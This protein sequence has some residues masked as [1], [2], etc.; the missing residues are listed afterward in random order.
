MRST[1]PRFIPT[2][3]SLWDDL[4]EHIHHEETED[5]QLREATFY[6]LNGL[7]GV[8]MAYGFY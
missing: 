1:D 7:H 8:W 2:I 4:Q 6:G 5:I 3:Q